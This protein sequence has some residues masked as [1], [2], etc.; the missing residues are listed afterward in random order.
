ME[1][2]NGLCYD[3]PPLRAIKLKC[4]MKF[5]KLLD[6]MYCIMGFDRE[7][8]RLNFVYWYPTILQ[9]SM[10]K[11]FHLPIVDDSSVDIMLEIPSIHPSI[12]NVKLYLEM[13][14][15][16]IEPTK[17]DS[18]PMGFV[19]LVQLPTQDKKKLF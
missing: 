5:N 2:S 15:I 11:Y 4:K 3:G 1:G 13:K 18:Q 8:A 19:P 6:K 16:F 9:S 7:R 17:H 12:S 14:L 10:I